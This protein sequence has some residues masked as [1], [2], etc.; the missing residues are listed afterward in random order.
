[1]TPAKRIFALILA[2]L[3]PAAALAEADPS[4][5]RLAALGFLSERAPDMQ[6]GPSLQNRRGGAVDDH[7]TVQLVNRA[8]PGM[9]IRIREGGFDHGNRQGA[10]QGVQGLR[11]LRPCPWL[12]PRRQIQVND[13]AARMNAGIGAPCDMDR[14]PLAAK[15]EKRLLNAVLHRRNAVLLPLPP[16]K[17]RAEIGNRQFPS[18]RLRFLL[19][20]IGGQGVTGAAAPPPCPF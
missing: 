9:E 18:L 8:E 2:L 5:S 6:G 17:R 19:C 11:N 15:G 20:G 3:F 7:I 10:E 16:G 12:F 4:A 14:D 13:L 1:M